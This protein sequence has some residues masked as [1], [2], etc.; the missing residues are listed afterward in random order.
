MLIRHRLI[1]TVGVLLSNLAAA[2]AADDRGVAVGGSVS[3][4]NMDG[5]TSISAAGSFEYRLNRV[6]G[7][8]IE[9]TMVPRL[10]GNLP[11]ATIQAL[12]ASTVVVP[13][14]IAPTIYPPPTFANQQGRAVM[15]TNNVR[16]HIPSTSDRVDPY[17]VA[18]GGV[19]NIRQS[20]DFV[21]L[22]F[23]YTPVSVPPGTVIPNTLR[24]I[25]QPITTSS[26]ALA[27][28]LGG[29]IG[30][31]IASQIWIEAD[32]RLFRLLSTD[33]RN[34]GRFGVGLRYRF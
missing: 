11:N 14:T 21:Y 25:T 16:L 5:R 26:T 1:L 8:E 27:L 2:A 19:A 24:P 29:G 17:F 12:E 23:I 3:A 20:A 9:A 32:L 33:D 4:A 28:T 34:L 31:R 15:F 13:N 10:K 6:A 7:L 22:P 18:G 30:V